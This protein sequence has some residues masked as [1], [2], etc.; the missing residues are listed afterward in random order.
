MADDLDALLTAWRSCRAPE[1]EKRIAAVPA[2]GAPLPDDRAGY[3][4]AWTARE[5][6]AGPAGPRRKYDWR[7]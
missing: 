3:D 6:E 1:L 4:A 2:E 5:K 7:R